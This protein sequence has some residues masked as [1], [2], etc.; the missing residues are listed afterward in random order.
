MSYNVRQVEYFKPVRQLDVSQEIAEQLKEAILSGRFSVGDKL[1]AERELAE[2]F[3]VSR[4]AIRLALRH[5][6]ID[7]LIVIRQ[8]ATGGAFVTVPTFEHVVNAFLTLFLSNK[9]S[10]RELI[11]VRLLVEPHVAWLAARNVT[12]DS[13]GQLEEALRMEGLPAM[14]WMDDVD[15]KSEVHFILGEMCGNRF[16]EGLV[17]STMRLTKRAVL[18]M[19][20]DP[21]YAHPAGWHEPIVRAVVAGNAS[22]ARSAMHD[23]TVRFKK[24][25]VTMEEAYRKTAGGGARR[26]RRSP[27]R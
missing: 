17:R 20:A 11:E 16:F 22:A 27:D 19:G 15:K 9:I 6:K 3:Q 1:P 2:R 25:M 7:G 26:A 18:A 4:A 8:G 24:L 12:A 13:A 14:S 21:A 10:F 23:H 5:L